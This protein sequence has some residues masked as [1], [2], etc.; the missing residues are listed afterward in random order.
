MYQKFT[1]YETSIGKCKG[2]PRC[3]VVVQDN[4]CEIYNYSQTSHPNW[5]VNLPPVTI[6]SNFVRQF[7]RLP[8]KFGPE[9]MIIL[10]KRSCIEGKY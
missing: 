1:N 6:S 3:L 5:P 4:M 7:V 2:D 9:K 8:V 10:Y